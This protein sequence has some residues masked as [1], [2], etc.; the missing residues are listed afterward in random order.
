LCQGQRK[1]DVGRLQPGSDTMD[2]LYRDQAWVTQSEAHAGNGLQL[3]GWFSRGSERLLLY[4]GRTATLCRSRGILLGGRSWMPCVGVRRVMVSAHGLAWHASDFRGT[5]ARVVGCLAGGLLAS[6]SLRF[7]ALLW[8]LYG[9]RTSHSWH[10]RCTGRP[11]HGQKTFTGYSAF[12]ADIL[13]CPTPMYCRTSHLAPALTCSYGVD[14]LC[15]W[16]R[17]ALTVYLCHTTCNL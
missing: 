6:C 17:L 15:T 7:A 8:Q 10:S 13:I 11:Q 1:R 3:V 4:W 16:T 2:L 5:L 14:V 9:A 12:L